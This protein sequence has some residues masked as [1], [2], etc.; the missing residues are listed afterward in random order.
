MRMELNGIVGKKIII[1]FQEAA[2]KD[3]A[4]WDITSEEFVAVVTGI[5]ERLGIWLRNPRFKIK[6]TRDKDGNLIPPEKQKIEEF[7]AD[8]FIPWHY[9]KGLLHVRDERFIMDKE[10]RGQIGFHIYKDKE[11]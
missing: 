10:D 1:K 5:D 7:D 2:V 11:I 4:I 8:I 9:I 6:F 3:F